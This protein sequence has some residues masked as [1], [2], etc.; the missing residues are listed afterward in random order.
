MGKTGFSPWPNFTEE[1]AKAVSEVLLSNKVNYWTGEHVA[2]FEREYAEFIG[3]KYAVALANGTVA[4][5]AALKA[6]AVKERD[7]V[8]VTSRSFFASASAIKAVGATPVFADVDLNTQNIDVDCLDGLL[9]KN[10]AAIICVHLA[11]WPCDMDEIMQFAK[12]NNLS[13][14]EDCAQ[15][16]GAEYKGKKVGSI[17]DVGCWSFCQDKIISTGGEGGMITT[18]NA[19]IWEKIWS[20]KDHGKD[21]EL[22]L[23]SMSGGV[24]FK[25]VHNSF[26][27]NLRMTEMQAVIGRIQIQKLPKWNDK[28][29]ANIAKIYKSAEKLPD[30]RIPKLSCK[31]C[32]AKARQKMACNC[33]NAAYKCYL[34][35]DGTREQ[36]DALISEIN[37]Q[38]V[39]C[40][41][42]SC[43]EIYLEKA[44][45]NT[46]TETIERFENAKKLG[47]TSIMFLCH[48]TLTEEETSY[49]CKTFKDA[50]DTIF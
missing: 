2:L 48:P 46:A 13:V 47:E 36:R 30:I 22:T 5:E 16:H 49:I 41:S 26:G 37:K 40:F 50:Y 18:N 42:G 7:E 43:P 44:F 31:S 15:A 34:F 24:D 32:R 25:W 35:V 39:P 45:Q 6:L 28:R 23:N 33:L 9:S 10:T 11:G 27:T 19:D 3:V 38:G 20:Y 4:I 8:I 21:Y 17:G 1:E 29:R 12:T 14:I